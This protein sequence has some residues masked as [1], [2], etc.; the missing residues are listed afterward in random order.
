MFK[1]HTLS[2]FHSRFK[3]DDDCFDYLAKLKWEKGFECKRCSHTSCRAGN[4]AR[5]KRCL[6]CGY[7]ESV[8][9]QTIF[10]KIKFSL[11]SAF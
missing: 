1:G 6:G 2:A 9:A 5:D 10:H 3:T 11:H 4:T 7:E 8:T